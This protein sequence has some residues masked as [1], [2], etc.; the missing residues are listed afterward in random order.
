M[1]PPTLTVLVG[2]PGSGKSTYSK[3]LDD[4]FDTVCIASDDIRK[5]L[6]GDATIQQDP[7]RVFDVMQRRAITA[8]DHGYNVVYD[9]TAMT[10]ANRS[11]IMKLC[12]S[13]VRKEAVVVSAPIDVCIDRDSKRMRTVGSEVINRMVNRFQMPWYDEGFD[14]VGIYKT[15]SVDESLHRLFEMREAMKIPHDN[16]HHSFN[17]YDHCAEAAKYAYEN[18]LAGQVAVAAMYHDCGK[19]YTKTI[20]ENGVA[21]YRNHA[22]VGAYMCTAF[23]EPDVCW[24]INNHMEPF[25]NSKYYNSM[26]D[27]YRK[28]IDWLHTCDLEAH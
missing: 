7:Q 10:R 22:N 6:Y 1:I 11:S 26:P 9:S 23:F 3:I 24:L 21:H 4:D 2:P 15:I 13:F 17:I 25:F 5:E 28:Y 16:P 8:L 27:Y 20:D 14:K 18:R 12:P 19:P